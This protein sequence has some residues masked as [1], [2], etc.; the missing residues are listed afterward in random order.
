[1]KVLMGN[2]SFYSELFKR[3]LKVKYYIETIS[4]LVTMELDEK[5]QCIPFKIESNGVLECRAEKKILRSFS[6]LEMLLT[7]DQVKIIQDENNDKK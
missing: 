2:G 4:Q 3:E 7:P 6:E 5:I 1:M